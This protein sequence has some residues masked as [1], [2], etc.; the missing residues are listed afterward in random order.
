MKEYFIWSERHR[1]HTVKECILPPTLKA[2]FQ[3][4]VDQKSIPNIML[5][6]VAGCGKTSV[7]MAMLDEIDADWIKVNASINR[8]IDTVR[9]EI[10]DFASSVSLKGGRKFII[11]DEADGLNGMAQD[12][13]KALIEE[14]SSNAGFI[15]TCNHKDKIIPE[16]HSRF[17]LIEFNYSKADLPIVGKEFLDSL[18][19]ILTAENVTYDK[20]TL[21]HFIQRVYPDWRKMLNELQTYSVKSHTIDEGILSL[22]KGESLDDLIIMLKGKKW[23]DM[24]KWVGENYT[25]VNNFNSFATR[26]LT[27]LKDKVQN[28]CL[29]SYVVLYN[30]YDYKQAFVL[31]KEI[32]V[33]AF[34][35]QVMAECVFKDP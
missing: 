13:L 35:T 32:N 6:G 15:I 3:A 4:F 28:S 26:L 25:S 16:L 31:D 22:N 29:P 9:N 10:M 27:Q 5:S 12:G 33:V 8:G 11:L 34:L 14:F 30:E 19:N 7:A 20:K 1:P 2:T 24:R 23:Q 17:A 18:C 21:A